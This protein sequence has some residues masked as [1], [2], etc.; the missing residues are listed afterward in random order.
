MLGSEILDWFKAR[1][2]A[3]KCFRGLRAIDSVPALKVKEYVI[4]NTS[5]SKGNKINQENLILE[6]FG[7]VFQG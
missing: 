5:A 6:V 1:P 2:Y 4:V 7:F 3:N